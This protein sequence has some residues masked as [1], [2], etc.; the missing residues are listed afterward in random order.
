MFILYF[1]NL[2]TGDIEKE[3]GQTPPGAEGGDLPANV[4]PHDARQFFKFGF[5]S[6]P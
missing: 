2:F 5:P 6:Q 3:N 1:G 4:T